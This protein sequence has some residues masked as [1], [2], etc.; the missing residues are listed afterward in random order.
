MADKAIRELPVAPE[1]YDDSLL[2]VEQQKEARSIKGEL[3]RR[4]ARE[5]TADYAEQAKASAGAAAESEER[6]KTS[7]EMAA[8]E[9]RAIEDMTVSAESLLPGSV[10]TA[11]KTATGESFSIRFGIPRGDK[12]DIGPVGPTGPRGPQGIQGPAGG[13]GL[14]GA[15]GPRGATGEKGDKGDKGEPGAQGEKGDKGDPGERG[16]QGI[17]GLPGP[18]GPQGAS[19]IT[20]QINGMFTLSGDAEGNLWAYYNDEDT[21]PAFEV[22]ASGNIYYIVTDAA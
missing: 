18:Q 15:Q 17:Q 6:T 3:I 1:L 5:A 11:E 22:D 21:P 4:F 16:P 8:K 20:V 9:R 7:A 19:G 13:Q 14:Q 10:A 2:V 12:G